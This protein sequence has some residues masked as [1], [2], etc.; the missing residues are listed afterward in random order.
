MDRRKTPNNGVELL[1]NVASSMSSMSGK[2]DVGVS[3]PRMPIRVTQNPNSGLIRSRVSEEQAE[4]VSDGTQSN[5]QYTVLENPNVEPSVNETGNSSDFVPKSLQSMCGSI[6]QTHNIDDVAK[7]FGV[8]LNTLKDIDNFVQ[9]LRLGKR[10]I[11]PLLSKEKGQE[12]MDIHRKYVRDDGSPK[13]SNSSPLVSLTATI[14]MPRGLCNVDVAATFEVPLTTVGDLHLLIKSIEAGKH[15]E[16]LSG[17][18]NDERMEIMDALDTICNSIQ[19][20]NTNADVIRCK[21]TSYAGA[22]GASAKDQP[23]VNSNFRHLVADPVFD[24]VNIYIPHKVVEKVGLEAILEGGPWLIRNS[25]IILKKWSMDT[26]L[27]KEELTRIPIWVKLHDSYC[28]TSNVVTP[29]VEKINDG[30]QTVDKKKKRKGKSKSTN[31]GQ[32]AGPSIKPNVRYES[33]AITS[34]PKKGVTNEGNASKSPTMSKITCYSSKND[35]IITS[36][37]YSA[38]NEEE[39]EEEDIENVYDETANLFP[40]TKTGESSSFTAA[41]G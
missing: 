28:S 1:H 20:N 4:G 25:P 15:D 39:D 5:S 27:F 36:N 8:P 13:V 31:V 2:G 11:W 40:N 26:R 23:K 32:F 29:T 7:L 34:A 35:N 24:G 17:M 3:Q 14:N 6:V 38:L 18:T 16:L 21:S 22:A 41:A 9:D 10:E 33:K 12:I 30:F 19:A 37:S